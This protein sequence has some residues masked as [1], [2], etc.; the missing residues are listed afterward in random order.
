MAEQDL[1]DAEIGADLQQMNRERVAQR[2][3]GNW[4]VGSHS[5]LT[6]R[7]VRSI[8]GRSGAH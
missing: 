1:D 5:T 7:Q 6:F 8:R 4:F 3:R 2:M